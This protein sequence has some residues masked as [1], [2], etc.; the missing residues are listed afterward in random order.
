MLET[1]H[2]ILAHQLI[3][4]G[5]FVTKN[6][7][8]R[9]KISQQIRGDNS[10]ATIS[11]SFFALFIAIAFVL[12]I[13]NSPIGEIPLL[14][15][16]I[17]MSFGLAILFLNIIISTASLVHLKDSWRVGVLEEQET[18]L[19]TSGIYRFSRNPYFASYILMFAAYTLL[20][21]NLLLLGLSIAGFVLIHKMISK[22][23]TY[24]FS[25][26]GDAYSEYKRTVPRYLIV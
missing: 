18:E 20:L 12:S 7:I 23:E 1:W 6:I 25:V 21:Q 22:E 11:I 8:L 19:I 5:M 16:S 15:G 4:Q 26:H 2:I 10:E 14:T 9:K 17:A 24:L 13:V 3:F